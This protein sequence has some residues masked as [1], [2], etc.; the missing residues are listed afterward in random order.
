MSAYGWSLQASAGEGWAGG[1]RAEQGPVQCQ[2]K[3]FVLYLESN[4]NDF[5]ILGKILI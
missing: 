1:L 3:G 4:G 2:G 5:R